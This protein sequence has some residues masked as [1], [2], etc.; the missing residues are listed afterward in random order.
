MPCVTACMASI[1]A[2]V[3]STDVMPGK[4]HF[5]FVKSQPGYTTGVHPVLSVMARPGNLLDDDTSPFVFSDVM[6]MRSVK[7]PVP[8]RL[9]TVTR[10]M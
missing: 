2:N 7:T 10:S 4:I 1:D 5:L 6:S 8:T 3:C 9:G